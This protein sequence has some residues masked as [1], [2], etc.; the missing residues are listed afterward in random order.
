[1]HFYW[2]TVYIN[3]MLSPEHLKKVTQPVLIR[4]Y[5]LKLL[6]I[7]QMCKNQKEGN[8]ITINLTPHLS[9]FVK[10]WFFYGTSKLQSNPFPLL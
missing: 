10:Y 4:L 5:L 6:I 2:V 7:I 1:M 3:V 8:F 9:E